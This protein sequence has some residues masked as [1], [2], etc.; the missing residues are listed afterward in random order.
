[1]TPYLGSPAVAFAVADG[2]D[3]P[4]VV[5]VLDDVVRAVM[6]FYLDGVPAIVDQ[7]NYALLIVADHGRDVLCRH[8]HIEPI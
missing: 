4:G 6:D 3:E 1:M 8:L 5:P 2:V 7:E